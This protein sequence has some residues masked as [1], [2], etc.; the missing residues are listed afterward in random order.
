[1]GT[2]LAIIFRSGKLNQALVDHRVG[3]FDEAGDVRALDVVDVAVVFGAVLEAGGV[4]I[5]HD[6]VEGIVHFLGRPLL[7]HGV[8]AHLKTG[9]GDAARIGCLAGGV[10]EAVRLED[11][12]GFRSGRHVGAFRDA[13]AAAGNEV[14]GVG[15]PSA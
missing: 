8:L 15:R 13:E 11:P 12:D 6:A 9:G 3:D 14:L 5:G 2:K 10:E 4:D 7:A 1:M